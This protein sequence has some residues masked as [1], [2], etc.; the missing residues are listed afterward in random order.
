ME[1]R[2][3]AFGH[4]NIRATHRTTL[5]FVKDSDL[6]LE[7]DCIIG[8]KADFD[9]KKLREFAKH[10]GKFV[11]HIKMQHG[12]KSVEEGIE[13]TANTLFND[14]HEIVLRKGDFRSGRTLG[15]HADKAAAGLSKEFKELIRNPGQRMEIVLEKLH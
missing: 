7:G 2:F 6:S 9:A 5:E 10:A 13:A 12:R 1:Y 3:T 11:M 15:M 14:A 4:P 8:V